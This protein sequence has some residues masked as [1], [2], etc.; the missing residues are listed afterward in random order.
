MDGLTLFPPAKLNLN[1][2]LLGRRTDGFHE[3][4]TLMI[5]TNLCDRLDLSVSDKPGIR[6]TCSD[7]SLPVN[8]DNLVV[9]A[10]MLF[11]EHAKITSTGASIHLEKNIPSGGGLGGGSSD[12]AFTLS[13]L[14]T[15]FS[16]PLEYNGLSSLAAQLGSDV[17]F[18]LG[19]P[20]ARCTGRGEIIA[21]LSH[22]SLPRRA[23]L[24]NPGFGIPTAWAYKTYAALP[25]ERKKGEV[26]GTFPWGEMRNDLEPPVFDKYLL[27]PEIKEWLANQP[28]VTASMMSG[29]GSTMFG[30]LEENANFEKLSLVFREKFG[31]NAFIADVRLGDSQ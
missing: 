25:P 28:G 27:L 6:F 26:S 2:F 5:R 11:M 20:A 30:I 9:K 24:I 1:L 10:A 15:L 12:A 31:H 7:A 29:S 3:L 18:F 21:P 23:I 19:S 14:N 16:H 4:D 8:A 22:E 17:P 13:G